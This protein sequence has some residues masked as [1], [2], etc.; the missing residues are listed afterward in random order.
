MTIILNIEKIIKDFVFKH[1]DLTKGLLVALS[2]GPDSLALLMG[3]S[4]I[5][6]LTL[7]VAHVDHGWRE[8]SS[9]EAVYLEEISKSLGYSFHLKVLDSNDFSG[10][11]ENYCRESRYSFFYDLIK[12]YD[13]QGVVLGHHADDQIETVLKRILEGSH[14][15]KL[16]GIESIKSLGGL[17]LFR[18][19]L[20]I[21]KKS[22]SAYIKLFSYEPVIDST[23]E[24]LSFLRARMRLKLL[25]SLQLYFGKNIQSSLMKISEE[26]RELT[27]YLDEKIHIYLS[28]IVFGP[29]GIYLDL[30]QEKPSH[31]YEMKYLIKKIAESINL[32][33]PKKIIENL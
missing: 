33:L 20:T 31:L 23:N 30:S 27:L 16:S 8:S 28:K 29:M 25:P 2:G 13:Y 15:T 10:N 19:L 17:K 21:P 4:K 6:G 14:L 7:A 3:L 18:P 22:L 9:R 24:D 32:S 26:A 11:L 12:K 5:P 1:L